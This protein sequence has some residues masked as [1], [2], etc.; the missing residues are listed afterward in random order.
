MKADLRVF[1]RSR[2]RKALELRAELIK[3]AEAAA[4]AARF[5]HERQANLLVIF[6]RKL[7]DSFHPI[8]SLWETFNFL[9]HGTSFL[10]LGDS[11]NMIAPTDRGQMRR[12]TA[13]PQRAQR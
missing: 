6:F 12:T 1:P 2:G 13:E 5:I 11:E 7:S 3:K 8:N 4:F 9:E 10:L